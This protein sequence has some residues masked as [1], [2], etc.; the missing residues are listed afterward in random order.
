[1]ET[2]DWLPFLQQWSE[3][4]LDAAEYVEDLPQEAVETR[5]LG[6]PG[7][8]EEQIKEAE[9]RLRVVLPPSYRE[10]LKVT[11][12]WRQPEA[13]WTSNAGSLWS[14]QQIE[15]FSVRNQ[16][17]INAYVE[18]YGEHLGTDNP[19]CRELQ[20]ALEMS[21]TGDAVYLLNPMVVNTEGEWEAW[22]FANW[23]PGEERFPSF[24]EML[25]EQYQRWK[26]IIT[27]NH[28]QTRQAI[29]EGLA[30]MDAGRT[31]PFE[32]VRAQWEAEKA[33]RR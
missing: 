18:P 5:W 19:F 13:F 25:Q 29:A 23:V 26:H 31:I 4:M 14:A 1:M 30:D 27:R 2:F 3:E 9:R 32:E 17:W 20:S 12:G 21:D 28:D 11:N 33:A 15:W 16:D 24:R 7:A 10:F 8:T 22:F 6:F